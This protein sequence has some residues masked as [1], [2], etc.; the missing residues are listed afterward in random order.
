MWFCIGKKPPDFCI[1]GTI[2]IA[3][4]IKN[5]YNG[6]KYWD[7]LLYGWGIKNRQK[8]LQGG[9]DFFF[10]RGKNLCKQIYTGNK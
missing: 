10:I 5:I 8:V 7:F 4:R 9:Q 1:V 2:F 6:G 3:N